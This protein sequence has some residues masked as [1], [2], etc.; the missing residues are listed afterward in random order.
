MGDGLSVVYE[1]LVRYQAVSSGTACL[2]RELRKLREEVSETETIRRCTEQ[3]IG[4][5]EQARVNDIML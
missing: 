3:V 4:P 5:Q 2:Y 1:Y